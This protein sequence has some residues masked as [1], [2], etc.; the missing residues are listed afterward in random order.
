M[1]LSFQTLELGPSVITDRTFITPGFEMFL[2]MGP[3]LRLGPVVTLVP[4]TRASD[5]MR[6]KQ[7]I[8]RHFQCK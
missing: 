8:M 5:R 3:L 2:Q 7:E 4:F 1:T 6:K